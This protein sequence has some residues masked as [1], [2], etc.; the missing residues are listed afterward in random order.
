M[1]RWSPPEDRAQTE[2]IP[3][4][5]AV[6][7]VCLTLSLYAGYVTDV[8]PGFADRTVDETTLDVVWTEVGDT[9][10][11]DPATDSLGNLPRERLPDGYHVDIVVSV[12]DSPGERQV[13]DRTRIDA[14]GDGDP[15]SPPA[16]ARVT[17][18]PIPIVDDAMPGDVRAGTLRVAVWN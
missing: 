9:G 17:S 12:E 10:V 5:V 3:A 18:R 2:P 1:P 8:L 14:H 13:I 7:V 11:Y 15:G 6:A 16:D 4:L